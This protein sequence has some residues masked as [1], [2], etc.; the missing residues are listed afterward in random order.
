MPLIELNDKGKYEIVD[1][2]GRLLPYLTLVEKHGFEFVPVP[3]FV[4]E[5]KPLGE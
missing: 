5:R 1:G 4:C 3:V 2:W